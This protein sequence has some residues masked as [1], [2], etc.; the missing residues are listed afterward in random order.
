MEKYGEHEAVTFIFPAVDFNQKGSY[1]CE[2]QK[3][4]PNQ[5]I[6]FPQ[7]TIAELTVK[8]R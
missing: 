2:Y 1:H 7:G 5:V 3:K 8:G 4:L 6:Y